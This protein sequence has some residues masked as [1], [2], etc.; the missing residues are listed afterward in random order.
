L[1]VVRDDGSPLRAGDAIKRYG[2]LILVTFALFFVVGPLAAAIVLVA[3]IG[4]MR[5]P[6]M[7][8]MH[9]RFAHT[10]VVSD[11]ES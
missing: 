7:Q 5:N 2:T 4:W 8:G 6:N 3:V 10:I 1:R 11:A 9:D